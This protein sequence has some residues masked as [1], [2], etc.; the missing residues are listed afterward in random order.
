MTI[1]AFFD[2]TISH[3]TGSASMGTAFLCPKRI[4]HHVATDQH[5]KDRLQ[6]VLHPPCVPHPARRIALSF[7]D[8]LAD[9]QAASALSNPVWLVRCSFT[10]TISG[11]TSQQARLP[12]SSGPY[13]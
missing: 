8:R 5:G 3:P 7:R 13:R 4:A 10:A 11:R 9:D 2:S 12:C 6:G 1:T